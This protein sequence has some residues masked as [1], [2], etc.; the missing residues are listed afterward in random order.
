M[1][2][3]PARVVIGTLLYT[4]KFEDLDDTLVDRR[5]RALIEEPLVDLTAADEYQAIVEAL[6]S[7]ATLTDVIK[8]PD[9][10]RDRHSEQG[11][12]DFLSRLLA[13]MDTLRPWPEA[14]HR[15]LDGSPWESAKS[16]WVIGRIS[17]D[18]VD[19]Q[20]RL[21][22]VFRAG[23]QGDRKVHLVIL[24][25]R[26]GDELALVAPWWPDSDHVAVLSRER[27]WRPRELLAA[28]IDGTRFRS[29]EVE[30]WSN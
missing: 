4:V 7:S 8:L 20:R 19:A 13:R 1:L 16:L 26:S 17:M 27:P 28:L 24:K 18:Y 25:L 6:Q 22:Y 23:T 12:R 5:A 29:D 11:F 14:P 30:L 2:T 15:P 9:P 10:C 3:Q 21:N